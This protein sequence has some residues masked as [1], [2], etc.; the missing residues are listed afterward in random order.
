MTDVGG[1]PEAAGRGGVVVPP[2]DPA[3]FAAACVAPADRRTTPAG[4]WPPPV[5]RTPWPASR[6]NRFLDDVRQRLHG[7]IAP[8]KKRSPWRARAAVPQGAK[9]PRPR[10]APTE[11]SEPSEAARRTARRRCSTHAVASSVDPLEAAVVLESRGVNDRVA[12]DLFGAADVVALAQREIRAAGPD[13]AATEPDAAPPPPAALAAPPRTRWFHLRGILY[14]VPALVALALVPA[15]DPVESAL[16]LGGLVVSWAWSYGVASVA[17]AYLGDRDPAGARRFLRRSLLVGV[18]LAVVVATVAVYAALILTSTMQVT[19]ATVLLLAG[20]SAYLMAAAVLLMTGHELLLLVALLPGGGG[21]RRSDLTG[22]PVAG[23]PCTG[24]AGASRWR[25]LRAGRDARRGPAGAAARC[26]GVERGLQQFG[27]GLL[28]PLVVLFPA[29]NELVNENYDALPLSVTLAALPLVLAMG[30]AEGLLH[31][32]R[33]RMQSLLGATSSSTT[34]AR[35]ARR[36]LRGTSSCSPGR[37]WRCRQRWAAPSPPCPAPWTRATS[38]WR[39]TT[40]CS[41]PRSSRPCCSAC[42]AGP[43]GC[44]RRSPSPSSR[45]RRSSC[46]RRSRRRPTS[47][48]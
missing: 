48:R 38:C 11:S 29:V 12:R 43:G 3:A 10:A 5:G 40:P 35:A 19:L 21:T 47:R 8:P 44:W 2:G 13:R 6:L 4:P 45:W 9:V 15:V 24:S 33:A 25:G 46:T 17:W 27:F 30:V 22:R 32:Y 18:V 31:R 23:R 28:V 41:V 42:W 39:S 37:S 36:A 14:A 20:Q 7:D 34:F 1:M 16:V 26:G